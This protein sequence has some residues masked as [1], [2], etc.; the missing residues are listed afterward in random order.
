MDDVL[1]QA[2]NTK[3]FYLKHIREFAAWTS[4][5]DARIKF[6]ATFNKARRFFHLKDLVDVGKVW[7]AWNEDNKEFI[8]TCHERLKYKK[9][10]PEHKVVENLAEIV[11]VPLCK[12]VTLEQSR[13]DP[14][15]LMPK[16]IS[17]APLGL[18]S[19]D[20]WHGTPDL[21][22]M[23][24]DEVDIKVEVE[25]EGEEGEEEEEEGEEGEGEEEDGVDT[26][27]KRNI[28]CNKTTIRSQVCSTT[29]VASFTRHNINPN[30]SAPA[31]QEAG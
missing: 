24:E 17:V 11:L 13:H 23:V 28:R 31:M 2:L 9:E 30:S 12:R 14:V 6:I 22:A 16:G 20:T 7:A 18:G 25:E 8:S 3:I 1:E 19:D 5:S 26:E 4:F 15:A 10:E 27:V 21:R 29:I